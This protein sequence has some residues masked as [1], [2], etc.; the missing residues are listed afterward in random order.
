MSWLNILYK[1][2]SSSTPNA[3]SSISANIRVKYWKLPY[4]KFRYFWKDYHRWL[5]IGVTLEGISDNIE[6]VIIC[7]PFKIKKEDIED[8]SKYVRDDNLASH[9]LEKRYVVRRL[10]ETIAYYRFENQDEEKDDFPLYLY[11]ICEDSKDIK[12]LQE[13]CAF[14]LKILTNPKDPNEIKESPDGKKTEPGKYSL[15]FQF[16]VKGLTEEDICHNESIS[17]DLVQSAFS[18][19]E[20]VDIVFND[21]SHIDHSDHQSLTA[22]YSLL[23]LSHINF[24]FIGSS[25]D[26]TVIGNKPFDDCELLEPKI[27]GDYIKGINP[28]GKKC[29]AYHWK[30]PNKPWKVFFKTVYSS[31]QWWKLVK[32]SAYVILLSFLASLFLEGCKWSCKTYKEKNPSPTETTTSE[33]DTVIG[34]DKSLPITTPS[35]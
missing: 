17:N 32:Y 11:E 30:L 22:E 18:K 5:D 20:I 29:I 35:N 21:L 34:H 14:L 19:S 6:E 4:K 13:G 8:L 3:D 15:Y 26:E 2:K 7:F 25:E 31:R 23:Q 28:N 24:A 9:I 1:V 33:K 12:D 16:R 10:S 27:W